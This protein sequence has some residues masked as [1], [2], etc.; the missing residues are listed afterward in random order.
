MKN[1]LEK[2]T[3]IKL[4]FKISWSLLK[5]FIKGAQNGSSN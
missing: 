4:Y 3:I 2:I 1:I 5:L